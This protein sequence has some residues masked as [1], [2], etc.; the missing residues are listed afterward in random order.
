[1][2]ALRLPQATHADVF[3]LDHPQTSRAKRATLRNV[4][5]AVPGR[6]R[7]VGVDFNRQSIAVDLLDAGFDIS[8]PA[9]WIWEGVTN[10]LTAEAVDS[11]LRQVAETTA[12]GSILLF[13]YIERAVLDNPNQYFGAQRLLTRLRSYG[14]PWTF[15][16]HP[17]EVGPY[18]AGHG[19]RL[20]KDVSVAEV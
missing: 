12:E 9:C 14:E 13:T 8:R 11:T 6:I 17:E 20:L 7:Y 18:V 4:K 5:E 10:Y 15:G 3:E 16:L 1:M 2:R 19:F